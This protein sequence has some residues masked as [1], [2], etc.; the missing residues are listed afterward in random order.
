MWA[1]VYSQRV[2][3]GPELNQQ[4]LAVA[5]FDLA[6]ELLD[7]SPWHVSGG[8]GIRVQ[9]EDHSYFSLDVAYGDSLALYFTTAPNGVAP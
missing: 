3:S 7:D 6:L 2:R 5:L 4:Q 1:A 9:T 8:V